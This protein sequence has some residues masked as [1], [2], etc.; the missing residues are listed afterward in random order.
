[1][2]RGSRNKEQYSPSASTEGHNLT[3]MTACLTLSCTDIYH[4][5]D[6]CT[7]LLHIHA[8][9]PAPGVCE[10]VLCCEIL[11]TVLCHVTRCEGH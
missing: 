4:L 11:R 6:D 3:L 10:F 9:V 7:T 5:R 1:M 2:D 8:Y